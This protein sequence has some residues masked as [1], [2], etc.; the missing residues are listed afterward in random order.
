MFRRGLVAC[1]RAIPV[2]AYGSVLMFARLVIACMA[3]RAIRLVGRCRPGNDLGIGL[4]TIRT[5]EAHAM[6]ARISTAVVAECQRR[7][8]NRA[9]ADI[10]LL[11]RQE[12][13][14]RFSG[15]GTAVVTV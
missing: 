12:V 8:V 5:T 7:P 6:I 14:G 9:V 13:S 11:I 2:C 1:A 3:R 10:A 15:G 4:V